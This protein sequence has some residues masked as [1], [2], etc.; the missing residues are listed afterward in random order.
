MPHIF[1]IVPCFV[2]FDRESREY[3]M[4]VQCSPVQSAG[5]QTEPIRKALAQGL[6]TNVARLTREGTYVTVIYIMVIFLDFSKRYD[7]FS[8]S[9]TL[10]NKSGSIL[11]R[12]C[13]RPSPRWSFSRS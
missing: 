13:S 10:A 12:S 4:T 7:K 8:F 5:N 9:L 2:T 3:D 11:P 1:P 6:F